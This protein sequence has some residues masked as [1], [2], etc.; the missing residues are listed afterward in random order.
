MSG[1]DLLEMFDDFAERYIEEEFHNTIALD[2]EREK[3][4]AAIEVYEAEKKELDAVAVDD[5]DVI[6]MNVGGQ[7]FTTTRSTLC[8]IE[9]SLL[10]SM[11]SGRWE[12][13]VLRDQDGAVFFDYNPKYFDFILAYLRAK[14]MATPENPAALPEVP[15]DQVKNFRSLVGYLGLTE[16]FFPVKTLLT[17]QFND[18]SPEITL[19]G[20]GK[21]AVHDSSFAYKYVV[22]SKT[23][24]QGVVS[25]KLNLESFKDN[26]WF[27]IGILNGNVDVTQ[28]VNT[29]SFKLEGCYAWALG[30][31]GQMYKGGTFAYDNSLKNLS[32]EGDQVELVLNCNASKLSLHLPSGDQFHMDIP[33][34]QNW[35][36]HVNLLGANDKIRI[37]EVAK[38]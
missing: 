11:F 15:D 36:L 2:D 4:Q 9:D 23:Y 32:K 16:E 27:M 35:R 28:S 29:E 10:A 33:T 6:H 24:Q 8:Q 26:H 12:N 34:S 14:T 5:D 22:G 30:C 17:D 20:N 38:I 21:V 18:R 7:K 31:G 1:D 37:V 13:S 3:L 25:F 19:E